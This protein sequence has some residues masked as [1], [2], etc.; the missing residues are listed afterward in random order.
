ML[1]HLLQEK[2]RP[3][4][5]LLWIVVVFQAIQSLAGLYLPTLNARIIDRGI[6]QGDTN[7]IWHVG[8]LMLLTTLV[9]VLL[10]IAAIYFGSRASMGFGRD[11]RSA[12]FHQV[13][14]FSSR[15]VAH[16]GAPSLITRITNDVQQVQMLVLMT[17]T[18]LI[19]APFTAIGG[20]VLALQQDVNLSW[21]IVIAI[22]LVVI[23]LGTVVSKMVPTF[24]VMQVRID[25]INEI[26]REQ[27]SGIRVVRAF[28]REPQ[29]V[30]R[31]QQAN[32]DVTQ[33]ALRGGRLMSLMFPTATFIVNLSC[34]AVVWF[35]SNRI[36]AGQMK[37]GPMVAF[38]TYLAQILMSVMMATFMAAL[39]PRAAVSAERIQEVLSTTSS[40]PIPTH[41]TPITQTR[42][43]LELR[44][45]N[46]EYPG[47]ASPV[48]H[49]ISFKVAAGETLA[50]I[51]S[52][53]SGKTTLLNLVARLFDATSGAVLID[54]VDISE[55]APAELWSRIGLVPQKPYLFSGTISSNLRYGKQ[56]AT[57]QEMWNALTI[58]QADSFV[59]EM[60]GELEAIIAQGGT[61]VSG[62]QRQRLAI[63]R[64]LIR[65]PE[66]YLFDD[67][68]SALDL[69]TDAK[70]RAALM[71]HL[72]DSA[73]LIV[74]Q[75]VS[76]IRHAN[77]ILV[78]E[79]GLV[80]GLGTHEEL[81]QSCA[82][83]EEIVLS[84][85]LQEGDD[86]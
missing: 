49:N 67:S 64:A 11:T 80:V 30:A 31:F 75:R 5:H 25:R 83:Y 15:E 76:T 60:P 26:L 65:Q 50:I 51:G 46:F 72:K 7:Y 37:L 32:Q 28:V 59:R 70:L 20:L 55:V 41:P 12:L 27:L 9:Q 24:R 81:R 63:A 79:D 53:G 66:I 54:G 13:N 35:G 40:V 39:W 85:A 34:V 29:E 86:L 74:G 71:P 44:N 47:A 58:A 77:Q 36:A 4:R 82:T 62:G 10:S 22:P 45:V 19:A 42:A 2:L 3:Y 73:T 69:S 78:L 84:Q 18:L 14:S 48:L 16:F 21:I 56:D 17:C 57:E 1:I 43:E 23:I 61:N 6:T 68:F 8:G 33:T 38:L 52:T